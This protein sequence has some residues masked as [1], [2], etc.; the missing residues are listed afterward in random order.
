M[1]FS[2]LSKFKQYGNPCSRYFEQF[3]CKVQ[4]IIVK[5]FVYYIC[6]HQRRQQIKFRGLKPTVW[7]QRE[8]YVASRLL[9]VRG[10]YPSGVQGQI[11]PDLEISGRSHPKAESFRH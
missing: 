10:F 5:S 8:R 2:S 6:R 1:S 7:Q 3:N 11:V 9:G 4:A